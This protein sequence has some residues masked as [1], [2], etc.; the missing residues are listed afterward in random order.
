MLLNYLLDFAPL[1]LAFATPMMPAGGM[2]QSPTVSAGAEKQRQD[3]ADAAQRDATLGGRS[4]TIV[5]GNAIAYKKQR[6]A[7]SDLMAAGSSRD[8]GL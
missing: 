6:Q 2:P 1:C 3:A 8:M 5:G 4:S 7:G